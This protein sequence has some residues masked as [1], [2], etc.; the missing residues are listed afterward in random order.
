MAP[1]RWTARRKGACF[2]MPSACA[3]DCN[4][5]HRRKEFAAGAPNYVAPQPNTHGIGTHYSFE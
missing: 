4:T 5:P 1:V 3:L 2:V